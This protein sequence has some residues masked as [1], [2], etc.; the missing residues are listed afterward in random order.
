MSVYNKIGGGSN[1]VTLDGKPPTERVNLKGIKNQII[2]ENF[3][4]SKNISQLLAENNKGDIIYTFDSTSNSGEVAYKVTKDYF[5]NIGKMNTVYGGIHAS[6]LEGNALYIVINASNKYHFYKLENTLLTKLGEYNF[7]CTTLIMY[8]NKKL[9][10]LTSRNDFYKSEDYGKTWTD[11]TSNKIVLDNADFSKMY[12]D[13]HITINNI[14][15]SYKY[16]DTDLIE[17]YCF[18]EKVFKKAKVEFNSSFNNLAKMGRLDYTNYQEKYI[19]N[20]NYNKNQ[21][22]NYEKGTYTLYHISENEYGLKIKELE[23]IE[24]KNIFVLD[25]IAFIKTNPFSIKA[26]FRSGFDIRR[27]L[28]YI[29]F[30]VTAYIEVREKG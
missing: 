19:V 6:F 13:K 16:I 23:K 24:E 26:A 2:Y 1:R 10:A 11:I 25:E 18:D 30:P 5:T 14:F 28:D 3:S 8:I 22:G 20:L 15:Y 7:G 4:P 29:E 9:Y 17:W 12:S 27:H 21:S